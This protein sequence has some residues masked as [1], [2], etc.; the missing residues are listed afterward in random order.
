MGESILG[1][2]VANDYANYEGRS[3]GCG[4]FDDSDQ[5]D[6]SSGAPGGTNGKTV[7]DE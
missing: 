3:N 6:A 5:S 7:W 1:T 2:N 4:L